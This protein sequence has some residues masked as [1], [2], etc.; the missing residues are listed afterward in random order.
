[1]QKQNQGIKRIERLSIGESAEYLGV[2]IDTL[3]RWGKK[4]VLVAYR[5]PGGHRYFEKK[6][7]DKLF[8]QRYT[9][10]QGTNKSENNEQVVVEKSQAKDEVQKQ[11]K[12]K[13]LQ[14]SKNPEKET[15]IQKIDH[16]EVTPQPAQ[17]QPTV[18]AKPQEV[19][20]TVLTPPSIFNQQN[21]KA[22]VQQSVNQYK[23]QKKKLDV[24]WTTII[25][26]GLILFTVVD[27]VLLIIFLT[28][29]SPLASPI[30]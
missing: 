27:L 10:V 24:S 3:R 22:P 18:I 20:S 4:G 23:T 14:E 13:F 6:D 28:S 5:S 30:P 26:I 21:Q 16:P 17:T 2:S 8:G 29:S 7:L 12:D 15:E 11:E 9:R 25:I 1:M 19:Q